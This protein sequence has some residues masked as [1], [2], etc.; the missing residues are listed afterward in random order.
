MNPF[1]TTLYWTVEAEQGAEIGPRNLTVINPNNT[2]KNLDNA[3]RVTAQPKVQL[4]G[5][6]DQRGDAASTH[7]MWALILLLGLGR[8]RRRS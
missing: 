6:C 2:S 5:G 1:N 3:V 4:E 7:W 8:V